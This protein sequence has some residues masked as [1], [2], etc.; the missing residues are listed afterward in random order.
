MTYQFL[1][2]HMFEEGKKNNGYIDQRLFKTADRYVF[3]SIV[4]DNTCIA[5]LD[6]YVKYIQPFLQPS[7]RYLLTNRNGEQFCKL[8]DSLSILVFEAIGKY[9]N[10][11]R[12]RQI[13]ETESFNNLELEECTRISEDQKHTSQ[14]AKTYYQKKR[15]R[16][17]AVSGQT[18]LKK[19]R[20]EEG[21]KMEEELQSFIQKK[22]SD[23]D[24][25]NIVSNGAVEQPS[26][27]ANSNEDDEEIVISQNDTNLKA[28][29]QEQVNRYVEEGASLENDINQ[30]KFL[31]SKNDNASSQ[32]LFQR[33]KKHS[34]TH[35]EDQLLMRAIKRHGVGKWTDIL[36]DNDFV[37]LK[38]SSADALKNVYFLR[39]LNYSSQF[40][41]DR[42][43]HLT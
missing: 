2:V 33:K 9:F 41:I 38:S 39:N 12:Y 15:S 31:P 36:R 24:D 25:S 13:I 11:T 5:I 26:E 4:L 3:D 34:S 27:D 29:T 32:A 14:V 35:E 40:K 6:G 30:Q 17:V 20:G 19:L 10:P 8:T 28:T 18:C 37:A 21:I 43:W 22:C 7:C 1:T 42:S 23:T 16:E